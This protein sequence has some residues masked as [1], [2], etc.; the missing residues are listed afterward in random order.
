MLIK[1][2]TVYD[3]IHEKPYV[4]DISVEKGKIAAIGKNLTAKRGEEVVDAKGLRVYPG[5]ID[6]HC[7]TAIDDFGQGDMGKDFNEKTS[8][9]TPELRAID[10]IY[11]QDIAFKRARESGVTTVCTGPGS[12]NVLGGT[13]AAVKTYGNSVEEML[14]KADVAMKCAFGENPKKCYPKHGA[15][16]RMAVAARLREALFAAREYMEKKEAGKDQKFDLKMEALI[17]VLKGEMPLKAHAHRADDVLTAIR[18]A[19]EFG[20]KITIEHGTDGA[21][22][23]R[24]LKKAGVSVAIGPI[25]SGGGSKVEVRAKNDNMAAVLDKA[26]VPFCIITDAPVVLQEYLTTSVAVSLHAGLDPFKGLQSITINAAKHIGLEDRI[27][28]LEVGKDADIVLC[29]GDVFD[30]TGKIQAV[31]INGKKVV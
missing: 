2:G 4:A 15:T 8:P 10:S 25:M 5:F 13:F 24:E 14:L 9:I 27:G 1:N 26:G 23:K 31:Y 6:A 11:P 30:Y 19:K 3:A 18:V 20:V 29:K 12:S 28:S 21:Q 7:H 22:I 17:P 16:V